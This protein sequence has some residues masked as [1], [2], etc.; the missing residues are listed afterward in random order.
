MFNDKSRYAGQPTYQVPDRFG[1]IVT[2]VVVPPPPV[3]ALLG[4]HLRLQGQ[5][6]DHIAAKYLRD[7]AGSWRL[8]EL[9][10]VMHPQ[11]MAEDAE[12]PVP[13]GRR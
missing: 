8:C 12:I 7:P 2:V 9:G 5:R 13:G 4:V 10:D 1:R 11:A 6:L 3:Q